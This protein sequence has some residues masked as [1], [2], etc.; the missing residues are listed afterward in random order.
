MCEP[1]N[2]K[3]LDVITTLFTGESIADALKS[4]GVSLEEYGKWKETDEWKEEIQRRIEEYYRQA[5]IILAA[6]QPVAAVKLIE[7]LDGEKEATVRQACL[8]VLAMKPAVEEQL[9][10][11]DQAVVL[12]E[13]AGAQIMKILRSEEKEP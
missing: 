7:L 2:Q 11:K 9:S 5:M 12:S 8:D 10:D 4:V 1:L 13:K 3:Q 6:Y